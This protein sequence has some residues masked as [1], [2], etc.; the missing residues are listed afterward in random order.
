MLG[1]EASVLFYVGSC[2]FFLFML[3]VECGVGSEVCFT[4]LCER[5]FKGRACV[6]G[7]D[8]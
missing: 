4:T 5:T 2:G 7:I 8:K 1:S 6:P 3:S